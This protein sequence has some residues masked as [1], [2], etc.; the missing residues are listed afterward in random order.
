MI[1]AYT[2]VPSPIF[3]RL[4]N[5]ATNK[6]PIALVKKEDG[7]PITTVSLTHQANGRYISSVIFPT[8]GYY[9]VDFIVYDDVGHTIKNVDNSEITD[10][11]L[12]EPTGTL[13]PE[14]IAAIVSAS[15]A[16]N[17]DI[18]MT[19]TID[20]ATDTIE[21][22]VW[23]DLNHDTIEDPISAVMSVFN[24]AGTL[25]FSLP[26]N[27]SPTAQGVFYFTKTPITGVIARGETYVVSIT[28]VAGLTSLQKL[29]S[30]TVF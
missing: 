6:Y 3:L 2:G 20:S 19:T 12:A 27:S 8:N 22:L 5:G 9:Y 4:Y 11:Y 10:L 16:A 28:I 13:T 23:S 7:T 24:G 1:R 29:K 26:I 21:F 18:D 30:F 25:I 14:D 15:S 17:R